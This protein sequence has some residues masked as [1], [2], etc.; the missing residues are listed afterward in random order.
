MSY[1]SDRT[2]S[3]GYIPALRQVVGP[4]LLD[5]APLEHDMRQA[6]DLIVLT[7]RDM[8]IG[9]RVRRPGYVDRYPWDFTI[10]STRDSGAKTEITKIIDG[11]G[12]WLVYAHAADT[13]IPTLTRWFVL[14]LNVFRASLI[15]T[16]KL[17]PTI[18]RQKSNRDGT[19]HMPY[20]VREF[21]PELV[22][23]ASHRIPRTEAA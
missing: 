10:R 4:L 1:T 12:D 19:Y 14:E 21:G 2:W 22:V 11:W 9:C 15:R 17:R 16:A 20:D 18:A 5:E 13:P 7:A 3:D 23:A 6:T 8:R